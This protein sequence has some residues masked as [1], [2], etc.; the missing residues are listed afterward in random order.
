MEL[1]KRNDYN[2]MEVIKTFKKD[3]LCKHTFL[4]KGLS[5]KF[6]LGY[7]NKVWHIKSNKYN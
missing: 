1:L 4:R 6:N 7:G 3:F 2:Q 5:M